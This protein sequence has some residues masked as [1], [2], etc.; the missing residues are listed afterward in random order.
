MP[1]LKRK[2]SKIITILGKNRSFSMSNFNIRKLMDQILYSVKNIPLIFLIK[3]FR[4]SQ[5]QICDLRS[6]LPVFIFVKIEIYS[7]PL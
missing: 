6:N 7:L 5:T 1:L 2:Y 4:T 3:S